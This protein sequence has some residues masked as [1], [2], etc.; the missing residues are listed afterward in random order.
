VLALGNLCDIKIW[1]EKRHFDWRVVDL[2]WRPFVPFG[3][4]SSSS[5]VWNFLNL[6]LADRVWSGNHRNR[7]PFHFQPS[8]KGIQTLALK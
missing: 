8:Y 4:H 7:M 6:V 5:G 3:I 1:S 2:G